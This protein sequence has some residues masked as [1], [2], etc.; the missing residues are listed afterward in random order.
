MFLG[1]TPWPPVVPCIITSACPMQACVPLLSPPGRNIP[2]LAC[3]LFHGPEGP[4]ARMSLPVAFR[5]VTRKAPNSASFHPGGHVYVVPGIVWKYRP[6]HHS[7]M[8]TDIWSPPSP[9]LLSLG[10][11]GSLAP[12]AGYSLSVSGGPTFWIS[13]PFCTSQA[14]FG[15]ASLS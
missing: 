15:G 11:R 14:L 6:C 13:T 1:Y 8:C 7:P 12:G 2:G 10:F 5:V 4:N 9:P 3:M